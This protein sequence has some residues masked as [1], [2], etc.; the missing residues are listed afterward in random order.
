MSLATDLKQYALSLG[1]DL[2]GITSAEP[3]PEVERIF[4]ERI[5]QGF[6]GGLAWFTPARAGLSTHPALHLAEA[7]SILSLGVSYLAPEVVPRPGAEPRGRISRYAW[8]LD[9][10]GVFGGKLK[11]I[12]GFL[13]RACGRPVQVRPF[14]DS[15]PFAEKAIARRSGI[16]WCG[17][18]TLILTR[19]WGS[20]IFLAGLLV[21]VELEQDN[22]VDNLC[23][24]CIACVQAC[25]T[26]ALV[27]PYTLD[28]R[29]C[30]SYLT[31]ELKGTIPKEYRP[32]LGNRVFGCDT[33]QEVCPSNRQ[34][35]PSGSVE[36]T[37][38]DIDDAHPPLLRLMRLDDRKFRE[39]FRGR[40]LTRAKRA[41]ILRNAAIA[42][43]NIGDPASVAT[44]G[45]AL[46]DH[47]PIVRRHVAW[48]LGRIGGRSA[49]LA[50]DRG[51]LLEPDEEVKTEIEEALGDL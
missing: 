2:A 30:L 32:L 42:L 35:R 40:P 31:V 9:Y 48:A 43:G 26:G 23:G 44:L 24:D 14:V 19:E 37:P 22:A 27:K 33:C 16:G 6:L 10:H 20:W 21:D 51:R 41:G 11:L 28:S 17:K 5:S 29:R 50:L 39:R 7:K 15:S 49:K 45:E 3:F 47:D 34:P 13:Q 18:N 12:H 46:E 38:V 8:G 25:P 1:F 36:F 4:L